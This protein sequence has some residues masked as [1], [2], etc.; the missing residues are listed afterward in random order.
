M[1][2]P[3]KLVR[4]LAAASGSTILLL[5]V[6][7]YRRIRPAAVAVPYVQHAAA[8]LGLGLGLLTAVTG[9]G[10]SLAVG[11]LALSG[12]EEYAPLTILRFTTGALLIYTGV[13]STA[14]YRPLK[15][16]SSWAIRVSAATSLLF[17]LY[18]VFLLPL[19]GTGGTVPPMLGGW[20][21]N[22]L[23]LAGAMML[24]RS[25]GTPEWKRTA[26]HDNP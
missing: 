24:S 2:N 14:L 12:A 22:F 4:I 15:A 23:F 18:L 10:H 6:L 17:C 7:V 11:S 9:V 21:V 16:G 5:V 1:V 20:S 26:K 3:E 8:A 19:P 25:R 13:M